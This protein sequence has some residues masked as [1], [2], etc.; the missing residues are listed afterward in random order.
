MTTDIIP[1]LETLRTSG[2]SFAESN[3]GQRSDARLYSALADQAG[4]R[5]TNEE[6]LAELIKANAEFSTSEQRRFIRLEDTNDGSRTISP[7]IYVDG[8][9]T[10]KHP[11]FRVQLVLVS[12]NSAAG[13]DAQCLLLRFETPE[14]IDPSGTGKHD[15]YHSQ[16]C[17][18]FRRAGSS[19]TFTVPDCVSWLTLSCPAWPLDARTPIHLL[20]C[21]IFALYGKLDG[22]RILQRAYG[23]TLL[24]HLD[25]MHFVFE[26]TAASSRKAT[27]K[28]PGKSRSAKT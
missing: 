7:L 15:Y 11:R 20:A 27:R 21:V 10:K 12:Y 16:L 14:G 2:L 13:D 9:F 17:T 3:I 22:V 1:L 28:M 8:D 24:K 26:D 5:L 4:T 25:G 18:S 6:D 23:R 19:D